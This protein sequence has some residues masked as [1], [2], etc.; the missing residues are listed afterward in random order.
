MALRKLD[1]GGRDVDVSVNNKKAALASKETERALKMQNQ[2][3]TCPGVAANRFTHTQTHTH[4]KPT[5]SEFCWE[6][7]E[8]LSFAPCLCAIGSSY[9]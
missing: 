3:F 8:K 6:G 5:A 9:C 7:V 4:T 2:N 1:Y